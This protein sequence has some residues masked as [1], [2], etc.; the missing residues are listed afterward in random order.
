[1]NHEWWTTSSKPKKVVVTKFTEHMYLH[2]RL[3]IVIRFCQGYLEIVG[4]YPYFLISTSLILSAGTT[5][6]CMKICAQNEVYPGQW[7]SQSP[8]HC[9]SNMSEHIEESAKPW[10]WDGSAPVAASPVRH[11]TRTLHNQVLEEVSAR[12]MP[13][14]DLELRLF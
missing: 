4:I 3:A 5:T 13:D 8:C 2:S 6:N 12:S 9:A 7:K 14:L 10:R 1:M 11:S